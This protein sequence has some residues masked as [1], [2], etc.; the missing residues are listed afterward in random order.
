M[1]EVLHP[2]AE[3]K[4]EEREMAPRLPDLTGKAIGFLDNTKANAD[5]FLARVEERLR[6]KFHFAEVIRRRKAN[7]AVPAGDA[8]INELVQKCHVVVNA[9]GD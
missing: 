6:E 2:T 1:I 3:A 5:I 8:I 9:F 7:A 4:P